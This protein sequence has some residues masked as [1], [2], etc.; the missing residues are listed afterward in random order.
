MEKIKVEHVSYA[1]RSKYQ[2]IQ[3]LKDVSCEFES[4]KIYAVTGE[5]GSGKSTLLS[6]LAGLDV[7]KEGSIFVDGKDLKKMDRDAYR[8][9]AASVVYQSFHL[10]PLLN[11]LENVMYPMQLKGMRRKEARE[12]A[13]EY[14]RSVG[15]SDKIMHPFP[16]MMSGGEQQRVA[17]ARALAGE[18][19]ILLA[20][21]PTGNLDTENEKNIA[22]ILKACA[23]ERGYTVIVVTHNPELA[24]QA[25]RIYR[26]KD[27]QLESGK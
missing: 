6:L 19:S 4:G 16:K 11:A 2:T 18:G 25:D 24:R 15:L 23:H 13:I 22:E 8:R 21:E 20:D 12:K 27:G 26:M 7:P 9:E 14:I 17:I 3:A 1:Y 10:F 5:S